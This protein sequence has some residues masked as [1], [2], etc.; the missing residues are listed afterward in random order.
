MKR[1]RRKRLKVVEDLKVE[2]EGSKGEFKDYLGS[3]WIMGK[4]SLE[5]LSLKKTR[6]S[7]WN[8]NR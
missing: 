5:V 8:E 7:H 6:F 3:R 1:A 2:V 4:G